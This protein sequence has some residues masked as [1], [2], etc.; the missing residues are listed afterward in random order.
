MFLIN[1]LDELID[2]LQKE[3]E[4]MNYQDIKGLKSF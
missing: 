2:A 4:K 3:G 1:D